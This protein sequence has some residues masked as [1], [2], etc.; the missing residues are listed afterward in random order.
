MS[1]TVK[2]AESAERDIAEIS[3]VVAFAY[4]DPIGAARLAGRIF[5]EI[6]TL[7]EM[8]SRFPVSRNPAIAAFGCRQFAVGNFNIVYLI[9][10]SAQ[11]VH[12][13]AVAYFRRQTDFVAGRL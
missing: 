10:E 6:A 8:P 7:A 4:G 1:Y 3:D 12:V 13:V 2:I 9:D 5:D 11:T